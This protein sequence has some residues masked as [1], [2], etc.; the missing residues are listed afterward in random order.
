MQHMLIAV[1]G[2]SPQVITETLYGINRRGDAWPNEIKVITTS[3]GRD[4]IWTALN[5]EGHLAGLCEMLGRPP[6]T[7]SQDDILVVPNAQGQEVEDARSV[8]D[9]EALADFIINTVRRFTANPNI[10]IHAS[11]AGGRKTMTFYLGYAMSLFGRHF[12]QLSHVLV[13]EPYENRSDFFYPTRESKILTPK[14]EQDTPPDAKNAIVTL[15]DIPFVRQRSQLPK[16]VMQDLGERISYRELMNLINLADTPERIRVQLYPRSRRMVVHDDADKITVE[17]TF[18][19]ALV[20]SFY[21]LLAEASQE[22]NCSFYRTDRDEVTQAMAESLLT[23]VHEV[24]EVKPPRGTNAE[25]LAQNLLQDEYMGL[26]QRVKIIER[27]LTPFAKGRGL[28][29]DTFSNYCTPIR[30]MLEERLPSDLV[31]WLEPKQ[32]YDGNEGNRLKNPGSA[33]NGAYG[34]PLPNPEQQIQI[35]YE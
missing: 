9:H 1:T 35:I 6:L 32:V 26:L 30:R 21:T 31:Q 17:M 8:E 29:G 15:A 13:S 2:M 19:N 18:P 20:T 14:H 23:K 28:D 24:L 25:A 7:L 12:D 22:G 4:K 16:L 27:S 10:S 33:K 34:I 3:K 11:I 5:D